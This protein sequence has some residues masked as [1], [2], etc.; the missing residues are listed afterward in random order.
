M[1][2][3]ALQWCPS[4][5]QSANFG[6]WE[7]SHSRR[8][9]T[10]DG[11]NFM[12]PPP[13]QRPVQLD[14]RSAAAPL[15]VSSSQ[16]PLTPEQLQQLTTARQGARRIGRAI[17]FAQFSGWTLAI[18]AVLSFVC[19]LSSITS[20]AMG[21]AMGVIAGIELAGGRRLRRMDPSAAKMLG[22]NQ[23]A[24]AVLL[25]AYGWVMHGWVKQQLTG[26]S[27]DTLSALKEAGMEKTAQDMTQMVTL[28]V[29]GCLAAVV[30]GALLTAAYYFSREKHLRAYVQQTPQW[31]LQM[32]RAGVSL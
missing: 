16:P 30:A 12:A 10:A 9:K 17:S 23:V 25:V 5:L 22:R 3:S 14:Y 18:F 13:Q 24:F 8:P 20:M 28:V 7:Q 21:A 6:G 32:Q 27:P 11:S 29:Y 31:I 15:G 19:G 1:Q 4:L 2:T 26:L